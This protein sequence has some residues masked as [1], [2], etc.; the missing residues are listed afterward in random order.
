MIEYISESRLSS[1]MSKIEEGM[2]N[3]T[4]VSFY[5]QEGVPVKE[6]EPNVRAF[7]SCIT[8]ID[9]C[10]AEYEA[11]FSDDRKI[12]LF[13]EGNVLEISDIYSSF[14][15]IF[16]DKLVRMTFSTESVLFGAKKGCNV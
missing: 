5:P 12:Y 13:V 2:S 7:M 16:G 1:R 14:K 9:G 11:F 3:E 6:M 10:E 15:E 8:R 4:C